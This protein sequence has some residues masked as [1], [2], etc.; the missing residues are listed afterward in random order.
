[1]VV[2]SQDSNPRHVNES[3]ALP[4]VP[5]LCPIIA[6]NINKLNC[7]SREYKSALLSFVTPQLNIRKVRQLLPSAKV[8]V[9]YDHF[10]ST[11]RTN[12]DAMPCEAASKSCQSFENTRNLLSRSKLSIKLHQ[13][14]VNSG[15][16]CN[17]YSYRA[18]SI[19]DEQF[20]SF[21]MTHT[22]TR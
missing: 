17:T 20:Y 6:R 16:H 11:C 3:D 15:G 21:C 22:H 2:P 19:S 5:T 12:Q 7:M 13:S 8:K 14:L 4:I 10:Y 1:M 9:K 18:T